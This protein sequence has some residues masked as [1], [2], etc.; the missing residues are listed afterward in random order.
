MIY[1][2]CIHWL[3]LIACFYQP[4]DGSLTS[5]EPEAA[6]GISDVEMGDD[7][8]APAANDVTAPATNQTPPV[9]SVSTSQP[10]AS[11]HMAA[12]EPNQ[13][14]PLPQTSAASTDQAMAALQST[15][16]AANQTQ[17]VPTL[18]PNTTNQ[19]QVVAVASESKP[20]SGAPGQAAG[21]QE[22][23]C[24]G[25]GHPDALF[26]LQCLVSLALRLAHVPE[27]SDWVRLYL[28]GAPPPQL[29]F[30]SPRFHGQM[31]NFDFCLI[32]VVPASILYSP[33]LCRPKCTNTQGTLL[34]F[35]LFSA[36]RPN[37]N[38]I[39]SLSSVFFCCFCRPKWTAMPTWGLNQ[40]LIWRFWRR[41]TRQRFRL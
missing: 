36:P 3:F 22:A 16:G 24:I 26:A 17:A 29:L 37:L 15:A 40:S 5:P 31:Y 41:W 6:N 2:S 30:L 10:P 34:V 9:P 21:N 32:E 18:A 19:M 1:F 27:G 11:A 39:S 20:D 4:I 23:A 8:S 35:N 12:P 14:P 38:F 33:Y 25:I 28:C 13:A 7:E